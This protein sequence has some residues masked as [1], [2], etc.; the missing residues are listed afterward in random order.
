MGSQS[1]GSQS[2]QEH[3]R[4]WCHMSMA[5]D[6]HRPWGHTDHARPWGHTTMGSGLSTRPC[7]RPWGHA[8]D[9]ATMG[10]PWG[11]D[12]DHGRPWG[13]VFRY[14]ILFHRLLTA[15]VTI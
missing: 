12:H 10:R 2:M 4:A 14:H 8:H 9:H 5:H 11:H 13:Q 6:H 15:V 7:T 3:A 1:M